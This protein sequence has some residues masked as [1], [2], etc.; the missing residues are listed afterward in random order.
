M[1]QNRDATLQQIAEKALTNSVVRLDVE[2]ETSLVELRPQFNISEIKT[3]T[4]SGFFVGQ[5]LIVTNFHVIAGAASVTGKLSGTGATFQIEGVTA[6]DVEND[7]ALLKVAYEGSPLTFGNSD[8]IRKRDLVCAIGYP[9][10]VGKIANGTIHRIKRSDNRIQM[11]IGMSSGSSGC[12]ILNKRGQVIGIHT[13]SD[14]SHS[15][16]IPIN[17]LKDLMKE[18]EE[19]ETFEALQERP[20]VCAYVHAKTGDEKRKHGEYKAAIAYYD[21]ALELN[22]DMA[23]VYAHR[24]DAKTELNS[25]NVGIY[26]E[27]LDDFFTAFRLQP[28]KLS[29]SDLRA[30]F[31]RLSVFFYIFLFKAL[32]QFL[33]TIFGRRGWLM[34]KGFGNTRDAKSA[35]DNGDTVRAKELYQEAINDY[36]DAINLKPKKGNTYNSRGWTKYLFGQFETEQGNT[37]EA[38]KLYQEAISDVN[39]ALQLKPKGKRCRSA[40][41]HT[42]GVAKVGL[43]DYNGAIEDFNESVQL[44][45]KKVLYYHDRGLAKEALGQHE[46]A[47]ADFAKAKEIDPNFEK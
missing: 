5:Q 23:D 28:F 17:T 36:T 39:E 37:A 18:T 29:V 12:P 19:P 15:Y 31:S 7:L 13:S 44:N 25:N 6:F 2:R 20:F 24:A 34:L 46:A 42:R 38:E 1:E 27:A 45:P 22:P 32:L 41:Y 43:D 10:G 30:F 33:K 8:S 47:R 9:K 11:E 21:A 3:S 16:A 4:G 35:A 14:N 40:F 26:M